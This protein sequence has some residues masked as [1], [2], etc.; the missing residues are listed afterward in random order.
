MYGFTQSRRLSQPQPHFESFTRNKRRSSVNHEAIIIQLN[1]ANYDE[2]IRPMGAGVSQP[3]DTSKVKSTQPPFSLFVLRWGLA[4][5]ALVGLSEVAWSYLLPA[6]STQWR[7]VLPE[8]W[9][10]LA[11]FI[12]IAVATDTLLI[13]VASMCVFLA[14]SF[15]GSAIHR[16]REGLAAWLILASGAAYLYVGWLVFFVFLSQDRNLLSYK[17]S[18]WGGAVLLTLFAGLVVAVLRAAGRRWR[19]ASTLAWSVTAFANLILIITVFQGYRGTLAPPPKI[20]VADLANRPN[21]VLVTLDTTRADYLG[22]YGHPWIQTPSVDRVA[23][24]GVI[25]DTAIAQAP[26]TAPSHCSIMTSVYPFE[27]GAEN[28]KPM[29]SGLPTLADVLQAHGYETIAFTSSTTTRSVNSRLQQGFQRYVD[30]LVPWS[31]VFGSDDFQNLILFYLLGVAENSQIP[32]NVV[33]DRAIDWLSARKPGPFFVWLHYFDP[34]SPYGSPA[35]FHD[36][37]NGKITDGAPLATDRERYAEDVSFSVAQMGRV[38]DD[39]RRRGLYDDSLIVIAADHGEAFGETHGGV[40]ETR[41]GHYLYDTTQH[42]PLIIKPPKS[43]EKLKPRRVASQVELIDIAPTIL[44]LIGA[45][46][47][48]TFVGRSLV[49]VAGGLPPAGGER[50]AH[51]FNVIDINTPEGVIFGQQLAIRSSAW[52]YITVPRV[53]QRE[54]FDLAADP[55]ERVNI[56]AQ[57]QEIVDNWHAL[58]MRFWNAELDNAG[59]PRQRL[60]PS[61]TR[62]LEALGYLGGGGDEKEDEPAE[63]TMKPTTSQPISDKPGSDSESK[64]DSD[65]KEPD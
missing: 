65:Y 53:E 44:D 9:T 45:S 27:H 56:A 60:A 22:C 46:R 35:P 12:L 18:L 52:K 19:A 23:A 14:T 47:P 59:D 33:T 25:F 8:S 4:I 11:Q 3:S 24:E 17:A 64:E 6:V 1:Y 55:A 50:D 34:H 10:G 39:L 49:D 29:K 16:R 40:S 38:L 61:L 43:A 57:R 26:S 51:S 32:G 15:L 5:G 13:L 30:S 2:M 58:I 42:V 54:L 28:G 48:A 62:Q 37:Y 31:T 63:K 21:I 36:M 7:A 20:P 41:H